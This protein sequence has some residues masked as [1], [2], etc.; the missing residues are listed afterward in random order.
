M[1]LDVC[2]AA[3][4]LSVTE[5]AENA[6]IHLPTSMPS[7]SLGQFA[8]VDCSKDAVKLPMGSNK[9]RGILWCRSNHTYEL[10]LIEDVECVPRF[11]NAAT[12]SPTK[13]NLDTSVLHRLSHGDVVELG[14]AEYFTPHS[15]AAGVPALAKCSRGI[16]SLDESSPAQCVP[17][18]AF[19]T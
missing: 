12:F 17:M 2:N 13:Q 4:P 16:I 6:S 14:C 5:T 19:T 3:L 1:F 9:Y 18:G 10:E 15:A 7:M 11:C 8:G